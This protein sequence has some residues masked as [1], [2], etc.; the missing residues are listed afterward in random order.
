[1]SPEPHPDFD[2]NELPP[3]EP[4]AGAELLDD[5]A[6]FIRRFIAFPSDHDLVAVVLWTAHTHAL[7]A[8]DSTPRLAMLSPEPGSGKTRVLEV[9]EVLVPAPM[10]VL[11]ASAPAIFR[12]IA[13][14]RPTLLLDEVDALWGNRG[15]E[16]A[17]D[18]RAL[19]NAGHR[20]GATIPRC[21][22]P[23]H[24][25]AKFPVYAA[26]A[27]AGLGDLPDTLMT[28]SIVIRMRRRAQDEA[29]EWFRHRSAEPVGHALRDRLSTWTKVVNDQ[30]DGAWPEM[31]DGI[32]D[33]PADT[34]EALLA[35][36]DAAGGHWPDIAR[37]ACVAL[38]KVVANRD[39]SLGVRLLADLR[40]IFGEEEVM[41]TQTILDR[42]HA[43][44]EAPWGDL[45]GKP[46]DARGLSRRLG[47]YG[48][49]STKVWAGTALRGYRR[50]DL[51]DAWTRYLPS[52]ELEGAEGTEGTAPHL[53]H[54]PHLPFP[55]EPDAPPLP[56]GEPPADDEAYAS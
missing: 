12:T 37:S 39:A 28:R 50:D 32:V 20:A 14:E 15:N 16:S 27:L 47:K 31:P 46:L 23:T 55:E 52:Q 13:T 42:L 51:W 18:L 33:R 17:E 24:A 49:S 4:E 1:M 30:L 43:M 22:G 2:A 48:I 38:T 7:D 29:V 3:W 56:D 53:P 8:F 21:V 25:V 6:C 5:V 9:L 34:W 44:D 40:S 10:H 45:R 11:N 41:A 19:L 54:L 26:V 36:A 35:I